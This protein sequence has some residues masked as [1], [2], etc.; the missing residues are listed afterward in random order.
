MKPSMKIFTFMLCAMYTLLHTT[1][2]SA[3]YKHSK[4]KKVFVFYLHE[5]IAPPAVRLVNKAFEQAKEDNADYILMR[6]NTFGG[7]LVAADSIRTM[8]QN[9]KIPV[10]VLVEQNAASAGALISISCDSIYM[11]PG[12]TIGAASVVN[13]SG[14]VMPDKYQSYMR[15]MMRASAQ[16]RGRDPNIAAGMVTPNNYLKDVADSG[17]VITL[18]TNEA[19]KYK[20]CNGVANTVE[21]VLHEAGL[22][23]C[24]VIYKETTWIDIFINFLL[25]PA[26]SSVLIL[27]ILG[28]IYFEVQHP[29]I[30]IPLFVAV[31]AAV[32][33]FAP[34]YIEGLA[35]Y[36]EIIVF[37]MGVL[38]V[39]L[40]IFVFPGHGVWLISGIIMVIAGL[41]LALL[42]NHNLDFTFTPLSTVAWALLRVTLSMVVAI[43]LGISFGGSIFKSGALKNVVLTTTQERHQAY[44]KDI[45][46]MR[47]IIGKKGVAG[48][49][50]R[51][52]GMVTVDDEH[53]DALTDGEYITKD[54]SILVKDVR[55]NY[56]V[57]RK[58]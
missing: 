3:Q 30:G 9:S 6:L 58:G 37:V 29:G 27:L 7:E 35:A 43:V 33:Y 49:D 24:E 48:T 44:S 23:G 52:A 42:G 25:N 54:E 18:T 14:E 57:V 47:E 53:Y 15:G 55:G 16:L 36:W 32:L 5:E 40:E 31:G 8:I 56:L 45:Q 10:L 17:K 2:S 28:G 34:L 38:L 26:V 41:T 4:Q 20:Y 46:T 21:E 51:P 1:P 39:L 50:L 13:Q 12:S 11:K 22:D 19:I